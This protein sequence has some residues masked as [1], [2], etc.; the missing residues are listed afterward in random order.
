MRAV[1]STSA[2]VAMAA[3]AFLAVG[4]VPAAA[5]PGSGQGADAMRGKAAC[6]PTAP[7]T[8]CQLF[9]FTGSRQSFTVPEK[10]I[11]LKAE[12]KGA[13][14]GGSGAPIANQHGGAGGLTT[15]TMPVKPGDTLSV[16]V[17]GGGKS[18]ASTSLG[19]YMGGGHGGRGTRSGA[20]G[21][22]LSAL[23][24]DSGTTNPLAIAG[25]G[26]GAP[27]GSGQAG[28][29]G[30]DGG[31]TTG[32]AGTLPTNGGGGTQSAGGAAGDIGRACTTAPEVGAKFQGGKAGFGGDSDSGGG[33]G[34]GWYGGGGGGCAP[35]LGLGDAG[36]GGGSGYVNT[37][38][39]V[40]GTTTEGGGAAAVRAQQDGKNGTVKLQWR[41][42]EPPTITGPVTGDLEGEGEPGAVVTVKDKDGNTVCTA[43]VEADG[44][45]SCTPTELL[46]CGPNVFTATQEKGGVTSDAGTHTVEVGEPCL[47]P[48]VI[49]DAG[50]KKPVTGKSKVEDPA[51]VTVRDQDGNVVCTATVKADGTWSCKPK[52]PL[53]PCTELTATVTKDG[54]TSNP[55][56]LY[57]TYCPP[58]YGKK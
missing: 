43:T 15:A 52:K 14:G 54:V 29:A 10:A 1:R 2:L 50:E 58:K 24:K 8:G 12:L 33:G 55:S 45:W 56:K 46:P 28:A 40:T 3:A 4:S 17:G 37:A 6:T 35:N 47:S 42:L 26:G 19:G 36:G 7:Y 41:L 9:N 44:S 23:W 5:A 16:T 53:P 21:G 11:E 22:G 13:S 18:G 34:G 38:L 32:G 20:G 31:G 51:T 25:G 48:P 27:G 49:T 39:G 30:G 57:R